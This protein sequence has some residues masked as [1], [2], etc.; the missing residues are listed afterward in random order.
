M[1]LTHALPAPSFFHLVYEGE[2]NRLAL[3][4]PDLSECGMFVNTTC[5][6]P[7]GAILKQQF[8]LAVSDAE[9]NTWCEVRYCLPGTGLGVEFISLSPEAKQAIQREIALSGERI[10]PQK[11]C[12]EP[13]RAE[14]CRGSNVDDNLVSNFCQRASAFSPVGHRPATIGASRQSS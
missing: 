10:Q 11:Q 7:E 2:K 9:V 4:T 8:R 3:K 14:Q 12:Q 1:P 13:N 5:L 6:F